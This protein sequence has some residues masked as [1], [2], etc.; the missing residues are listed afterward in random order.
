M[1]DFNIYGCILYHLVS[2]SIKH[3]VPYTVIE[4]SVSY[5]DA[6]LDSGLSGTLITKIVDQGPGMDLTEFKGGH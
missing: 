4:I 5:C 1:T 2:N 6:P 3:S